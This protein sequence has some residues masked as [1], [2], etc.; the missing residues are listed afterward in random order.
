MFISKCLV[1]KKGPLGA[2]WVAAYFFKKLKKSQIS[3]T[4][5]P[6]SVDDILQNQLEIVAYRVLAYL[7][8]GVVRIY[9]K[10][11]EYLFDDCQEVLIK[12]NEFVV[13]EKNRA[14]KEALQSAS[15]SITRPVCFELDAFDL[16][17]LEDT[18]RDNEV[19]REEIT[20]KDVAWTNAGT[21]QYSLDRIA[22]LDDAF[23][24]D[25]IPPED[26][27]CHL[28][29]FE[30]EARTLH[31]VCESEAS[32]EKL[33]CDTS[34]HEEVSHLKIVCRVE[35]E[36]LNIVKVFDKN[37][38]EHLEVPDMS[39]LENRTVQ[40]A[41]REKN[42]DRFLSEEC[43]SLR[44]EAAEDSLGPFKLNPFAK[45]QTTS[46]MIEGPDLLE[47]ENELNQAMEEDHAC[48]LEA[49]AW[50]PDLAGS[51]SREKSNDRF[52]SEEG[53]NLHPEAE[54][55]PLIPVESLVEDLVNR[56]KMGLH[57]PQSKNEVHQVLEEDHVSMKASK[58][59]PGIASSENRIGREASRENH[60][61]EFCQ[62]ECLNLIVEVE[63][64]SPAFMKSFDEEH[65]SRE[66]KKGSDRV[67]PENEVHHFMEEGCNSGAG[68]KKLQAEGFSDMDLQEPSTLVRP[69]AEENQTDAE[70]GKFP[71]TRTS[72]DGKCQ[73]AAKDHPLSVTL[74]TN[75]LSMLRD[76][77]GATTP[78]FMLIPTPAK[79]ERARFSRKRKCLFDEVIVFPNDIMR[80]W[81]KD[82]SDLVSKGG[83][84]GHTALGARRPWISS[85]PQGFLE[86]SVPCASELKSI[87]SGKRLRILKSVNI[88][89]PPEQMDTSE[90][91]A[92]DGSFEQAELTP[93]TVEMRDPPVMLNLSKSPL[94][95][96]SSEQAGIAPQ[97]P[98]RQST[99]LV[100]G[101]QTEIAPQTPVLYS[102][103]LRPFGSPKDLKF[104]NLDV[105][106]ENVDPIQSMEK[107]PSLNEIVEKE[108]SLNK[109]EDLDLNLDMHS[110]EDDN[111]GQ[112]GWSSRTRMVAERLQMSFLDQ[113]EKKE[114][115]KVNLSQLLEGKT[116][117]ASV[118]LFY[119]I[120]V[121][122]STG[123]VDVQQEEAFSDIVV[124]KGPKWEGMGF[125]LGRHV[126]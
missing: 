87:Y 29:T 90:P 18:S 83:K 107:E 99:S 61:D 30:T 124:V 47:S 48:V 77:S 85:L 27:S 8:L 95:D 68:V 71:A 82:A 34:I 117:K 31:D 53:M 5:I 64:K 25:Y 17:V 115:E 40:E 32:M 104:Y 75:P 15:F 57:L 97:T 4:N 76:A 12:I 88:I 58:E 67:Q 45:D 116:K 103:S 74:D 52:S 7:L 62:E 66:K 10:K 20:L 51:S 6:S 42:N 23:L 44:F 54:E 39:G 56:E 43:L 70:N 69:L 9:S 126:K 36:P 113:R 78:H 14:K 121:L 98:S 38:R 86:P 94:F 93:A 22:A 35:E 110:N 84:D 105:G 101:E 72:K 41:N 50:V 119:E 28:M 1:S 3:G 118:R 80:Q 108:S 112:D 65:T 21:M 2:I 91:S 37:E 26:L 63:E 19:P 16:E 96:G 111:Q 13:R 120:L 92:V 49:S 106:P 89:K 123:L 59:V 46:G 81:I 73:V 55:E 60:N 114:E 11:V 33:R 24:I 109:N 100:V 125:C 79:R 122:K 102:K